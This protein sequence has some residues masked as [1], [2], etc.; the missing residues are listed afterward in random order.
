MDEF[1][2]LVEP[3]GSGGQPGQAGGGLNRRDFLAAAGLGGAALVVPAVAIRSSRPAW[4][5]GT[6]SGPTNADWNALRR[7]LSSHRL[8]R[9]GQPGYNQAKKLFDPDFNSLEPAGVAYC[10]SPTDVGTCI[11]FA[12]RF[13]LPFRMRSGG[14]S[15]AGYSSV[16]GGLI[17][18]VSLMNFFYIGRG[19]AEVGAGMDLINFYNNLAAHGVAVPGGSCPTVGI[20]GLTL[21]GGIGVLA[22][23]YGLT[24]DNLDSV[25]MVLADGSHVTATAKN[26]QSDLFWAS[27]GG[28]GGNF[29][30]ATAF[31]FRT[32][33]APN[34]W[35]FSLLWPWSQAAR[36]V[37]GWERWI[38]T[39]PDALWSNL[40]LGAPFGGAPEPVFVGGTFVGSVT[41]IAHQ[42]DRLYSLVGTGPSSRRLNEH[43][44]LQAMLIFAGCTQ[45]AGC[46]TPPGGHLPFVP[47]YAK[48]DF[49]T[50]KFD[51]SGLHALLAGIE[52]LRGIRGAPGGAGSIA[53]D[54]LGGAVN[55]VKADAT[56]FVHRNAICDAQ[57]YTGWN[58]PGTA[59]GKASQ[60]NW[61][62]S[63][64]NSMRPYAS[65]QAYQNYID[66]SLTNWRQ[67]YYGGNYDRLSQIKLKYDPH[68]VFNFPQAITPPKGVACAGPDC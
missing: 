59:S 25:Q 20:A 45:V 57:Y 10:K 67:A 2:G 37:S 23:L 24:S 28:G 33:P 35:I 63:Y 19:T 1:H 26:P 64:H 14:H 49:F 48:S 36:V 7:Q 51:S 4:L 13:K 30:V 44:F 39:A 21:G 68:Q 38:S 34:I 62:T 41:D 66:P 43:S 6:G 56:A 53:F 15:Y 3:D 27:Q 5:A 32:H 52:R 42:L 8:Y 50:R 58:Y 60:Y 47:F 16:T 12:T 9:P 17:I 46:D 61:L 54:G 11:T 22:R 31:T 65:G 18:D 55:R 40:F 29:G